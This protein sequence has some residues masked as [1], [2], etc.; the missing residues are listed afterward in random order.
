MAQG[1]LLPNPALKPERAL[2]ADATLALRGHDA[3][4]SA[5]AFYS[6]YQD[7]IAYEY[8][9]PSLVKPY[10]FDAAQA[11]GAELE[12]ELA[13]SSWAT[14]TVAYTLLFSQNLRDV[15]PLYLKE[16]P[17]RP[18]HTLA[19]KVSAGPR[20]GRARLEVLLH[21]AANTNRFG[22]PSLPGHARVNLGITSQP[23][24]RA[25]VTLA[26]ELKNVLDVQGTDLT[27]Y[28]LPGRS[29]FLTLSVALD[30][31]TERQS[32]P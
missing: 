8:Y 28:A 4:V 1:Q 27:D 9:P 24:S 16:L 20:W 10:N 15:A 23:L 25:D 17:F 12:A 18:R 7:L 13:A 26:V 31:A 32:R 5:T 11:Y 22:S 3:S 29:A 2:Y 6:L 30:L 21:S 19:A 14:A